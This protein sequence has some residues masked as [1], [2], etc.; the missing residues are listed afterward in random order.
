[1]T[2]RGHKPQL[3]NQDKQYNGNIFNNVR[4]DALLIKSSNSTH[5]HFSQ[6]H[7]RQCVMIIEG[8]FAAWQQMNYLE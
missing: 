1:M 8:K 5:P 6:N 4:H 3:P 7:T 2:I